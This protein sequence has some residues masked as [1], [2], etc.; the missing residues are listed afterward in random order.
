MGLGVLIFS[1]CSSEP[2]EIQVQETQESIA[3]TTN[4]LEESFSESIKCYCMS[5]AMEYISRSLNAIID[6]PDLENIFDQERIMQ[7]EAA[8]P[9]ITDAL[10]NLVEEYARDENVKEQNPPDQ[11]VH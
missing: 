3:E 11:D 1:G 6:P 5:V 8:N 9:I 2:E 7:L 4:N 10:Y